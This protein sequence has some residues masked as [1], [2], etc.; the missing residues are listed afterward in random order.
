[1]TMPGKIITVTIVVEYEAVEMRKGE[2]CYGCAF[3]QKFDALD[4]ELC[5]IYANCMAN[6]ELG[7]PSVIY[8]EK[9]KSVTIAGGGRA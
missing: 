6:A 2:L 3:F 7:H 9:T 1:M 8:K 4:R 5:G